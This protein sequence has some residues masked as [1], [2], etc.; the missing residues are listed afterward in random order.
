MKRSNTKNQKS[1]FP[2]ENYE[3][4]SLS[5]SLCW[6]NDRLHHDFGSPHDHLHQKK[7][8]S[9]GAPEWCGLWMIFQ[10]GG[11]HP[12]EPKPK[13]TQALT[14]C[15]CFAGYKEVTSKTARTAAVGIWHNCHAVNLV[16]DSFIKPWLH[17]WFRPIFLQFWDMFHRHEAKKMDPFGRIT[18]FHINWTS[19]RMMPRTHQKKMSVNPTCDDHLKG[20]ITDC[21]HQKCDSN[22]IGKL[23]GNFSGNLPEGLSLDDF[24]ES[25]Q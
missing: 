14:L 16:K 1:G 7:N 5:L 23:P 17:P 3:T 8:G 10:Y 6:E 18:W 25:R 20:A 9:Y 22:S 11:V 12:P 2:G 24:F 4:L 19:K 13:Q 21:Y 15:L